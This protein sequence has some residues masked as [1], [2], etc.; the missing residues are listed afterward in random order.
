[1]PPEDELSD[2]VPL[3]DENE[4]ASAS[5]S[6]SGVHFASDGADVPMAG[7][8]PDED[9]YAYQDYDGP[10]E[11][12]TGELADDAGDEASY[13]Y[14]SASE[15]AR[16]DRPEVDSSLLADSVNS[17]D[18]SDKYRLVPTESG[19]DIAS[20]FAEDA[21]A[22]PSDETVYEPPADAGD[23]ADDGDAYASHHPDLEGSSD[24]TAQVD[25]G[26]GYAEG[27]DA[28][29][30]DG[31]YTEAQPEQAAQG[32]SVEE[33]EVPA[34]QGF[35]VEEDE[36]PAPAPAPPA[37]TAKPV[38]PTEARP[39]QVRKSAIDEMFARAAEIKRQKGR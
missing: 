32:F 9:P 5:P 10:T 11:D 17:P 20:S 25:D 29:Y 38:E 37:R 1:M 26:A 33:E 28:A 36:A 7:E 30:T 18:E 3:S 19:E 15:T 2:E 4:A 34:A 24:E 14:D 23:A 13:G 22:S 6:D 16:F 39:G 21:G 35:S 8:A 31:S 27:A 12:L